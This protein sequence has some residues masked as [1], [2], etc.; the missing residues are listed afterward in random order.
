[1]ACEVFDVAGFTSYL[2][3]DERLH[4]LVNTAFRYVNSSVFDD[5]IGIVMEVIAGGI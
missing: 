1:M 4:Y 3:E 5:V 2:K